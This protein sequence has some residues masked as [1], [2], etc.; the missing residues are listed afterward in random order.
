MQT[1]RDVRDAYLFY[2]GTSSC[3][4]EPCAKCNDADQTKTKAGEDSIG[5]KQMEHWVV[6]GMMDI[7]RLN[8]KDS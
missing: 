7:L 5:K 6:R 4:N 1:I 2:Y 8:M 3:T